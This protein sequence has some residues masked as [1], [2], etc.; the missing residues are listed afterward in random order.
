MTHWLY[1][2]APLVLHDQ[3]SNQSVAGHPVAVSDS[4]PMHHGVLASALI[5][6]V[7]ALSSSIVCDLALYP[8]SS[9]A[10]FGYQTRPLTLALTS[11]P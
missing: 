3:V 6:S 7:S 11:R 8:A 9:Q 10:F 1:T 2:S 5:C 4:M